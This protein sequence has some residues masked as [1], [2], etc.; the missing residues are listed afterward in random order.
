MTR[1]ALTLAASGWL[2]ACGGAA[3]HGATL[4]QG[5]REQARRLVAEDFPERQ[6]AQRAISAAPDSAALPWL[7]EIARGSDSEGAARAVRI[8]EQWMVAAPG[9][10]ADLA[11]E[12]L[13][14]LQRDASPNAR[15]YAAQTL[16]IQ[17]RLRQQRATAALRAL[18]AKVDV[19]PDVDALSVAYNVAHAEVDSLHREMTVDAQIEAANPDRD[20][21]VL[22]DELNDPGEHHAPPPTPREFLPQAPRQVFLTSKWTGGDAGVRH[23]RRLAGV[24]QLQVYVVRGCGTSLEVVQAATSEL[25]D[26]TPQERGPSLGVGNGGAFECLVGR[27]LQG[28]AAEQ[29]GIEPGD[30]VIGLDDQRIDSFADLVVEIAQYEPGDRVQLTI[31]RG[32]Q[33]TAKEVTLGDWTDVD[34]E[35]ELWKRDGLRGWPRQRA[36]MI[37]PLQPPNIP[38]PLNNP[39]AVPPQPQGEL[40]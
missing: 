9:E 7:V 21:I 5:W 37:F 17:R 23:L 8:L 38:I 18:G 36:P 33:V 10:V 14:E 29:A 19:G 35:A 11:E 32:L 25:E 40:K 12:R 13:E 1:L 27:V 20:V 30:L 2:A 28:G 26:V 4:P 16:I 15:R 24:S 31:V 3:V 34:T 22:D 6:A 39:P